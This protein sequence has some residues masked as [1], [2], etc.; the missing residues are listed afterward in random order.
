LAQTSVHK[1]YLYR[2][3]FKDLTD[4]ADR[5]TYTVISLMIAVF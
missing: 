2:L 4:K 5:S 1:A 3:V